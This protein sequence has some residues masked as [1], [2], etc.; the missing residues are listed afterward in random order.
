MFLCYV[1]LQALF[2]YKA[3]TTDVALERLYFLMLQIVMFLA[4]FNSDKSAT[5]MLTGI[6]HLIHMYFLVI[7]QL[8]HQ[9]EL[10]LAY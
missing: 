9:P 5:A 4:F 8:L 3:I 1:L 2:G 6:L 10:N 7:L